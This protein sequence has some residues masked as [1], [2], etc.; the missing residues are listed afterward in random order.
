MT[1]IFEFVVFLAVAVA[2]VH[3]KKKN[4]IMIMWR[5]HERLEAG[6]EG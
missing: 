1:D 6:F 3:Q 5:L 4:T 2:G